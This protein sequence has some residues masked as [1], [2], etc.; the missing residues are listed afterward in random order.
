MCKEKEENWNCAGCGESLR[1]EDLQRVGL[2][3]YCRRCVSKI[4]DDLCHPALGPGGC[5]L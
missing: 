5:L 3:W 2:K 1:R 4:V